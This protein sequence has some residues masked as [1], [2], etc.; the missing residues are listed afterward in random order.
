MKSEAARALQE[1]A[2]GASVTRKAPTETPWNVIS[3]MAHT[4]FVASAP[5]AMGEAGVRRCIRPKPIPT[6]SASIRRCSLPNYEATPLPLST[7]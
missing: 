1:K 3:A 7:S 5:K 2:R 6:F 4:M